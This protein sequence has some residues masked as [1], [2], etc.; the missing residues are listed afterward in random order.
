MEKSD[1]QFLRKKGENT[2]LAATPALL[3]R[4][5][6]FPCDSKGNLIEM[7]QHH[8]LNTININTAAKNL[9]KALNCSVD[10]AKMLVAGEMVDMS[11]MAKAMKSGKVPKN[12]PLEPPPL[13]ET[14]LKP[15]IEPGSA[16]AAVDPATLPPAKK[17]TTLIPANR[18]A[19]SQWNKANILA[20][21]IEDFGQQAVIEANLNIGSMNAEQMGDAYDAMRLAKDTAEAGSQPE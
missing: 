14:D 12:E 21:A 16:A 3:K 4:G 17:P 15:G 19:R 7:A 6:L 13:D 11:K 10:Q 5:D 2:P 8:S 9:A 20:Y 18:K 1:I